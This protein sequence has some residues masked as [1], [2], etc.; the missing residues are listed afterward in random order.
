MVPRDRR[1][2]Y[3]NNPSVPPG[4]ARRDS[5]SPVFD[6]WSL[7]ILQISPTHHVC[8]VGLW[9]LGGGEMGSVLADPACRD[10]GEISAPP[11]FHFQDDMALPRIFRVAIPIQRQ[12]RSLATLNTASREDT[13]Q[14]LTEKIVQRYAVDLPPRK[15]VRS[16]DYVS[17]K[18]E[19][20]MSHDNCISL[21]HAN[22]SLACRIKVNPLQLC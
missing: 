9:R 2:K 11:I 8:A 5:V 10:S 17:I 1:V 3:V 7:Q 13:G 4:G 15:I 22:N 18:P 21:V 16:G 12:F 19:H 6:K 20:C 14:N